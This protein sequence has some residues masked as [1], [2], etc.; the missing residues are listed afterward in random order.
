MYRLLGGGDRAEANLALAVLAAAAA[1]GPGP[2]A[3]LAGALDFEHRS[4]QKLIKPPKW[5]QPPQPYT[6]EVGSIGSKY[7][8]NSQSVQRDLPGLLLALDGSCRLLRRLSSRSS[9]RGLEGLLSES[10]TPRSP[11]QGCSTG[12]GPVTQNLP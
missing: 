6:I 4:L 10:R 5:G 3:Q 1:R 9:F 8:R 12:K 11:C 7:R 2:A